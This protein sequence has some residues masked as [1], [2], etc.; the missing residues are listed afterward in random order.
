MTYKDYQKEKW[1]S[2]AVESGEDYLK[3]VISKTAFVNNYFDKASTTAIKNNITLKK[4]FEILDFGCGVGR[5]SLWL[6]PSVKKVIGVDISPKMIEIARKRSKLL[7]IENAEFVQFD[8]NNLRFEDNSFDLVTCCVVLKYVLDNEDLRQIIGEICR[9]VKP[10]GSIVLIENT[11]A[12]GPVYLGEEDL[13]GQ[14]ILRPKNYYIDIFRKHDFKLI[15]DYPIFNMFLS[16]YYSP[17]A[18]KMDSYLHLNL[19]LPLSSLF[20]NFD[21]ILDNL[22]KARVSKKREFRLLYFKRSI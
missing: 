17:F 8:D 18:K 12:L 22:I 21:L 16:S 9:V 3:A 14:S 4:D 19:F 2:L 10:E 11:D 13:S 7:N 20:L 5:I 1:D 6:A 15:S